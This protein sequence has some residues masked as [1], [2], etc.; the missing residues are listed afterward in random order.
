MLVHL[1]DFRPIERK[2]LRGFARVTLPE[3][4]LIVHDVAIHVR[5][6]KAWAS[7]PGRPMLGRDGTQ[8][9]DAAG[10]PPFTPTISFTSRGDQDAFNGAI[11]DAV[12]AA[13]PEVMS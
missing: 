12:R 11:V 3:L 7:P 9:R 13:H 10:K 6:A 4:G 5:E 1:D 8:L 2:T